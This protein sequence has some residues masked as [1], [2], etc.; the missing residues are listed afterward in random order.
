MK[1]NLLLS[2]GIAIL[3]CLG[4]WCRTTVVWAE[5][6]SGAPEETVSAEPSEAP[7][8]AADE[9]AALSIDNEDTFA[10]M[11][12][13]YREGYMPMVMDDAAR[14]VLPLLPVC[15]APPES[16][17]VAVGLGDPETSPFVFQNYDMTVDLA[18]Q[19]TEG[20]EPKEREIYLIDLSLP[21][22]PGYAAGRYP[23]VFVCSGRTA[24]GRIFEQTFTLFVTVE[25]SPSEP[26]PPAES[27]D[28]GGSGGGDSGG[29]AGAEPSAEPTP[30]LQPKLL[31]TSYTA[32]PAPVPAGTSFALHVTLC[33]TSAKNAAINLLLGV[34]G[35]G[36]DV[37]A[38]SAGTFYFNSVAP[39]AAIDVDLTMTA[40]PEAVPGPKK[41]VLHAGYDGTNGTA[42]T[43]DQNITVEVVQPVRFEFD[44]TQIPEDLRA[45]ETLSLPIN[46][47]NLGRAKIMN[48]S[49]RVEAPGLSAQNTLFLGNLD[50]G[51]SK[52]GNLTVFVGA[53]E[54]SE[55][56]YGRTSGVVE[57][58]CEDEFGT[59]YTQ[60]Q[61]FTSRIEA[62]DL[63]FPEEE[64]EPEEEPNYQ[65]QISVG[66]VG[67]IA[68]AV[69]WIWAGKRRKRKK[70]E[71]EDEDF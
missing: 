57:V 15:E 53:K 64:E 29:S 26:E 1:K 20:E 17:Q 43:E 68:A 60:T 33:N 48:V 13:P 8:E 65:W 69:I 54:N 22:Q 30:V 9:G 3:L 66:I 50:S 24:S 70:E 44:E 58:T 49:A 16:I 61:E 59:A 32:S 40:A 45:G 34:D 37:Y 11:D 2:L 62:P 31:V 5:V 63:S 71:S 39:G 47:M 36:T 41:I 67:A 56:R 52:K 19:K 28:G 7:S 35:E 10:G 42:Y 46:V 4:C 51:T 18:P 14:L 55:E 12:R 23:V 21:L 25:A 6:P 27:D 38:T